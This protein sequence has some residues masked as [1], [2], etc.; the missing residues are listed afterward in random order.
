MAPCASHPGAGPGPAPAASRGAR[1][2]PPAP[3]LV[4]LHRPADA[5]L[6]SCGRPGPHAARDPH[7]LHAAL[8]TG[9]EH[10]PRS[11]PAFRAQLPFRTQ[12]STFPCQLRRYAQPGTAAL[13]AGARALVRAVVRGPRGPATGRRDFPLNCPAR[14]APKRVSAR[15]CFN[16]STGARSRAAGEFGGQ[17]RVRRMRSTGQR[18]RLRLPRPPATGRRCGA[19]HEQ[20]QGPAV[21]RRPVDTTA[22]GRRAR[23]EV[24]SRSPPDSAERP[25]GRTAEWCGAATVSEAGEP[26]R[27]DV[28]RGGG[29]RQR[30][31]PPHLG[32]R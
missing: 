19:R 16:L 10:A 29:R 26:P 28:R 4:P 30:C 6:V 21:A 9:L 17:A 32:R 22:S 1:P 24:R 12:R 8:L 3:I 11:C 15:S 20:V 18:R 23:W 7:D 13:R 5:A 27:R 31:A 14:R 25:V 2:R